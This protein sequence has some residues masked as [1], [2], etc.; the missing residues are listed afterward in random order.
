MRTKDALY[1]RVRG[2]S[3]VTHDVLYMWAGLVIQQVR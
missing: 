3:R 2:G 1:G